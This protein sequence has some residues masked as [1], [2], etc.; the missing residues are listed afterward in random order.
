MPVLLER[1]LKAIK[2]VE[3]KREPEEEKGIAEKWLGAFKGAIPE[4]VTSTEY[5]KKLRETGYDK[6]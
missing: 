5:L 4:D 1:V 3:F 6:Y 2:N